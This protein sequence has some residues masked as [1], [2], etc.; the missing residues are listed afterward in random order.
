MGYFDV[1]ILELSS[2]FI[3]SM[4]IGALGDGLIQQ[5]NVILY[6]SIQLIKNIRHWLMAAKCGYG[7]L[8]E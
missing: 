8:Y 7:V 6:S 2:C 5:I 1:F 4:L 3:Y